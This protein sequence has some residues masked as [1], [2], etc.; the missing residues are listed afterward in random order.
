MAYIAYII[1]MLSRTEDRTIDVV[2][3][4]DSTQPE[5][6]TDFPP[7]SLLSLGEVC[8][9]AKKGLKVGHVFITQSQVTLIQEQGAL[10]PSHLT[11]AVKQSPSGT[12]GPDI[13]AKLGP[14]ALRKVL[15]GFVQL[16]EGKITLTKL[17]LQT[18][19]VT[20]LKEVL[21]TVVGICKANVKTDENRGFKLQNIFIN[22]NLANQ[23]ATKG[24]AAIP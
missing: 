11:G 22:A 1:G 5:I 19:V 9:V 15:L 12:Q 6:E 24:S 17:G 4:R 18:G 3:L 20:D 16:I 23:I 21:K 10:E 13:L 7:T 14:N 2:K 8:K